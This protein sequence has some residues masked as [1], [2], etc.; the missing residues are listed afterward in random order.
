MLLVVFS[1]VTYVYVF[2]AMDLCVN[3]DWLIDWFIVKYWFWHCFFIDRSS[4]VFYA[5][6][7]LDVGYVYWIFLLCHIFIISLPCM[8]CHVTLY[9]HYNRQC[10]AWCSSVAFLCCC[11]YSLFFLVFVVFMLPVVFFWG[12]YVYVFFAMGLCVNKDW[13]I[14]WFIAKYCFDIVSLNRSSDVLYAKLC[15]DVGY[16]YCIFLLCHIFIIFLLFMIL[17]CRMEMTAYLGRDH[18]LWNKCYFVF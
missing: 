17:L 13:L 14:D 4:D 5:S 7:C 18:W 1:G 12:T 9:L 2:F 3:K 10:C 15:L 11:S 6:L 16:V 8:I